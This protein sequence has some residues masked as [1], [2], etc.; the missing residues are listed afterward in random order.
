MISVCFLLG[1]DLQGS[2]VRRGSHPSMVIP[3]GSKQR[4]QSPLERRPISR[5][6]PEMESR[7]YEFLLQYLWNSFHY[8]IQSFSSLRYVSA[9]CPFLTE[10]HLTNLSK[11]SLPLSIYSFNK[12][13]R[14]LRLFHLFMSCYLF[15]SIVVKV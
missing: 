8:T 6:R 3:T 10:P 11:A 1:N 7:T 5:D 2:P 14:N 13:Y 12:N 9:Q 4:V 15:H